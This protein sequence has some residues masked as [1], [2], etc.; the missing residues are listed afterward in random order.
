MFDAVYSNTQFILLEDT[1][2]SFGFSLIY[3]LIIY[4]IPGFLRIPALADHN[5]K[6]E[7]LYKCSK[8]FHII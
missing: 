2:I 1:L 4:L 3:P 5:K 6:S 7:C 8:I